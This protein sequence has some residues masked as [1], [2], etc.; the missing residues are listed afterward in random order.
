MSQILYLGLSFN[1]IQSRKKVLKKWLNVFWHGT[2]AWIK[3][4][5]HASRKKNVKNYK[6]NV[7]KNKAKHS[8]KYIRQMEKNL[9]SHI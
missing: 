9:V 2:K 7:V 3:D 1:F 8:I 6:E 4:L 5:R